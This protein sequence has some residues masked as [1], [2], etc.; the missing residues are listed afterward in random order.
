MFLLRCIYEYVGAD[1]L[2]S[3]NQNV[4]MFGNLEEENTW[5]ELSLEQRR[6]FDNVRH[7]NMYLRE[8]FHAI[9]DLLWK[10][11]QVQ[12]YGDLPQR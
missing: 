4:M 9:Q 10:S 2:D 12:Y 7:F 1:I 11:R 5:F 3:T 6:H 8:Q